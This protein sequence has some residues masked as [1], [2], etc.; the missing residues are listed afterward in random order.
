MGN[1]IALLNH[2]NPGE[3]VV[4]TSD[5]HIKNYEHGAASF[6]SRIQFRDVKNT[7]G[8][9]S[10]E[11]FTQIIEA[12]KIHKPKVSTVVIE[13]THLA[14]GGSIVPYENIKSISDIA[15]KN[16]MN[17]HIDGARV[18]HAI[19]VEDKGYDYGRYADSL[20]FC[21]SKALGAP[22]GSILLGLILLKFIFEMLVA[23]IGAKKF[24]EK[25]SF[26]EFMFWFTINVPYVVIMCVCSFFV[27]FIWC[28]TFGF[29]S[30]SFYNN[31]RWWFYT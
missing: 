23:L 31:I 21:F 18:W 7:D 3:E 17:L 25:I 19:L 6:L 10:N 11:D 9:I 27:Q 1:Q 4:T 28:K 26:L 8:S 20:T 29:S 24:N 22:V 30:F 5:S 12:S 15:K 13:N 2:T 16:D 14:S